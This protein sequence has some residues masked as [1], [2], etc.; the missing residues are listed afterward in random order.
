MDLSSFTSSN[1]LLYIIGGAI[2]LMIF[3]VIIF[4]LR[5][6]TGTTS[7]LNQDVT[8]EFWGVFDDSSAYEATITAFEA[9]NKHIKVNYTEV[10]YADY[11]QTLLNGLA[12]GTGPDVLMIDRSWLPKHGD[13]LLPMP[14]TVPGTNAPLMTLRQFQDTFVDVAQNDLVNANGRIYALPLYVDTLALYYNKDLLFSAGIPEPPQTWDQF[15]EAVKKITKRD[16]A[17]NIVQSAAAMGTSQNVNRASDIL[18]A[19]MIES[20][21]QMTNAEGTEPTF[22]ISVNG[23]PVG[24]TALKY[25]TQFAIPGKEVYTWNAQQNYSIDAFATGKTAMMINYSHQGDLLRQS[26]PRLNFAVAPIPQVNPASVRTF[27]S[28]W[29]PAV[30]KGTRYPYQAWQFVAYLASPEG[31]VPYLNAA[32]RPAARKDLVDQQRN[33]PDLGVFAEQALTARNWLQVDNVAI[34]KIFLDAIDD[35]TIRR[36]DESTALQNAQDRVGVLMQRAR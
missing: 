26:N 13:K 11:E 4:A 2:A 19:L 9:A 33:D 1:R 8:L 24:A 27:A 14:A 15:N 21:T 30:A 10:S 22:A 34:E 29:A 31:V 17:L 18:M 12:A 35:V 6:V 5:G 28:Y 7:T 25:Y 16:D 20:G 36:E 32:R 23:Q 3:V